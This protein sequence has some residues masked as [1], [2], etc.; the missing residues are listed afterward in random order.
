MCFA[1][2]KQ[3]AF[4]I[5]YPYSIFSLFDLRHC[6]P[7][8]FFL[9]VFRFFSA[10]NC[11]KVDDAIQALA[12]YTDSQKVQ[13]LSSFLAIIISAESLPS[14]ALQPVLH[15]PARVT[16]HQLAQHRQVHAALLMLSWEVQHVSDRRAGNSQ[17]QTGILLS[18]GL[19]QVSRRKAGLP[20]PS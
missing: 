15:F 19:G 3:Q 2:I 10:G 20:V 17:L 8:C 7:C 13:K 14:L 11:F 18:P 16:F 12:G 1:L 5:L 6:Q 4:S 9:L